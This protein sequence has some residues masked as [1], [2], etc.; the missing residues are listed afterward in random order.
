MYDQIGL[1]YNP[2]DLIQMR[3]YFQFNIFEACS[4]NAELIDYLEQTYAPQYFSR[5]YRSKHIPLQHLIVA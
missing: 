5:G 1:D 2:V 3:S 4:T